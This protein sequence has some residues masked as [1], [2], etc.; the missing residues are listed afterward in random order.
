MTDSGTWRPKPGERGRG[1]QR[2]PSPHGGWGGAAEGCPSDD[3]RGPGAALM[4]RPQRA[5]S[6]ES[7]QRLTVG[8]I[9][10][11]AGGERLLAAP[12]RLCIRGND[13]SLSSPVPRFCRKAE[14]GKGTWRLDSPSP[15]VERQ[16]A[17]S[18]ADSQ[19]GATER[20]VGSRADRG[21]WLPPWV[22]GVANCFFSKAHPVNLLDS[23]HVCVCK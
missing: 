9:R 7:G 17:A 20:A 10:T 15:R 6:E 3:W 21:R 13:A 18:Q 1:P 5:A 23:S 8:R 19:E 12:A 22:V 16:Q 11:C 14:D 2:A 4:M